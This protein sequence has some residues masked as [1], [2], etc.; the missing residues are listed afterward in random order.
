LQEEYF[1]AHAGYFHKFDN[2][3]RVYYYTTDDT[4][5]YRYDPATKQKDILST[6]A[7]TYF[8]VSPNGRY[9]AVFKREY[10]DESYVERICEDGSVVKM[11]TSDSYIEPLSISDDGNYLLCKEG[12]EKIIYVK[13]GEEPKDMGK[14][15]KYVTYRCCTTDGSGCIWCDGNEKHYYYDA[16]LYAKG[17]NP[18][19][20]GEYDSYDFDIYQDGDGLICIY[21]DFENGQLNQIKVNGEDGCQT[22]LIA[23]GAREYL[24]DEVDSVIY[25][26]SKDNEV[27]RWDG[28]NS[29]KL[30][31][32]VWD[33]GWDS[34]NQVLLYEQS[35]KLYQWSE[36][37]KKSSVIAEGVGRLE[38]SE[39]GCSYSNIGEYNTLNIIVGNGYFS[40]KDK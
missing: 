14:I 16:A 18:I 29:T 38:S 13:F 1:E 23:E 25:Y 11:Y 12:P 24:L 6:D 9:V 39:D 10:G 40:V 8:C 35:D 34:T 4:N 17:E 7:T 30:A 21:E 33:I 5:I 36:S 31:E 15:E 26:R 27:M 32:N 3:G 22:T 28:D 2:Q 37:D 20:I 19:F